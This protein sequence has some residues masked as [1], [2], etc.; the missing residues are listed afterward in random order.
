MK[1]VVRTER[2]MKMYRVR[3]VCMVDEA[4]DSLAAFGH[5]ESRTRGDSIVSH[6]ASF[7]QVGVH[8]LVQR[9]D[10]NLVVV[11]RW[12]SRERERSERWSGI[13]EVGDIEILTSEEL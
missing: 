4:H 5:S 3:T 8:L 1:R 11:D 13:G 10:V 2:T 6:Q 7:V 9:M 12:A